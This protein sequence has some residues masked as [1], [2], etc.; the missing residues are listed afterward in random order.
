MEYHCF[1]SKKWGLGVSER[2]AT[3]HHL[4]GGTPWDSSIVARAFLA[5]LSFS[6]PWKPKQHVCINRCMIHGICI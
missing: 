6:R 5:P 3:G 1:T 4:P 2:K